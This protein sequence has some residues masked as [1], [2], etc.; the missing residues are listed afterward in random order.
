ME[1]SIS[2]SELKDDVRRVGSDTETEHGDEKK[3]PLGVQSFTDL[4]FNDWIVGDFTNSEESKQCS[5]KNTLFIGNIM[6][7][8]EEKY[9]QHF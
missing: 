5:S 1:N 8:K 2:G 6:S 4:K 3:L 9:M 7:V